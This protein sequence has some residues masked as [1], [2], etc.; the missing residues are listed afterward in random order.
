MSSRVPFHSLAHAAQGIDYKPSEKASTLRKLKFFFVAWLLLFGLY[1]LG[2]MAWTDDRA[3]A[4]LFLAW[5]AF[6][7]PL[8]AFSQDLLD[9]RPDAPRWLLLAPLLIWMQAVM[10]SVSAINGQEPS[11]LGLTVTLAPP[12]VSLV[13]LAIFGKKWQRSA[14]GSA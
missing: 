10:R 1:A 7:I 3:P 12:V 9:T 13:V 14:A 2:W 6:G 5:S 11:A 8:Y 4:I